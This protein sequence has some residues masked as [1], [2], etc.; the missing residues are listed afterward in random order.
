MLTAGLPKKYV[1]AIAGL[2]KLFSPNPSTCHVG[3]LSNMPLLA[4]VCVGNQLW[5]L[6]DDC[7][8]LNYI[9]KW[10]WRLARYMNNM[11]V[12]LMATV[13]PLLVFG[14]Y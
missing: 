1:V 8:F 2:G 5:L 11:I 6:I 3:V 7:G 4:W 14:F 12:Y 13:I 9:T 10:R